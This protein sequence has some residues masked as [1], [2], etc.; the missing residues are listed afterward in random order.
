MHVVANG[1]VLTLDFED[2]AGRLG[3]AQQRALLGVPRHDYAG[4][5]A[6]QM[7]PRSL[8]LAD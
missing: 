4:R 6:E 2:A 1:T 5:A 7:S 8:P 3:E